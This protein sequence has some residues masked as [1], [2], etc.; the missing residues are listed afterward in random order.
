MADQVRHPFAPPPVEQH[1]VPWRDFQ[2]ATKFAVVAGLGAAA[3][4]LTFVYDRSH[5]NV[6]ILWILTL[7]AESIVW[8]TTIGI[9]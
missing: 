4:Y 6:P 7:I 8:R 2:Q 9:W 5:E 1:D 3:W